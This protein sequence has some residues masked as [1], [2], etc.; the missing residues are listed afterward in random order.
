MSV[1]G[2][3]VDVVD[4]ARARRL[5]E[6]YGDLILARVCTDAEA[7][8]IR[9]HTDGAARLAVRLA[10]KEAAFK[11]LA[12]TP[13]AQAIGWREIEVVPANGGP[14]ELAFHGRAAA[15]FAELGAAS[16]MLSLSHSDTSAVAVVA[17]QR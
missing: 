3:G 9:T 5:L 2:L 7:E 11:A 14:P 13:H 8:Y 6:R 12:G 4:V 1:V 10:A 16:A 15:R 17:I